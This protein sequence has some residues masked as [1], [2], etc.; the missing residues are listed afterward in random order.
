[1]SCRPKILKGD[2]LFPSF[3]W[4]DPLISFP[5]LLACSFLI[6]LLLCCSFCWFHRLMLKFY[7]GDVNFCVVV[8][9]VQ[10][11]S[12]SGVGLVRLIF[13][14]IEEDWTFVF[15]SHFLLVHQRLR[16]LFIPV[17]VFKQFSKFFIKIVCFILWA[18]VG[19]S[20]EF[21]PTMGWFQ[22]RKKC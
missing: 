22:G 16:C 13:W 5:F 2:F 3:L 10:I 7:G 1:M 14:T 19:R 4:C 18:L 15:F 20:L 21:N 17:V 11:M 12:I 6:S 8:F 9:L